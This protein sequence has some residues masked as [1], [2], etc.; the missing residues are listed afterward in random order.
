MLDVSLA[1]E[2][3]LLLLAAHLAQDGEYELFLLDFS[4]LNRE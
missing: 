1:L 2:A 3:S 4:G